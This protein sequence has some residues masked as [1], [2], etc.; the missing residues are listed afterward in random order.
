MGYASIKTLTKYHKY[1]ALKKY[2]ARMPQFGGESYTKADETAFKSGLSKGYAKL[3][4]YVYR[5]PK[6]G[7]APLYPNREKALRKKVEKFR[8][9][10]CEW[11]KELFTS[12][13]R[14]K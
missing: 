13:K 3:K 11:L 9:T 4:K 1:N 8:Q 12:D 14:R 6:D 7:D 5:N 10:C 2:Y